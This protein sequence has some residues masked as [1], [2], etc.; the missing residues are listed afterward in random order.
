MRAM[1]MALVLGLGIGPAVSQQGSNLNGGGLSVD[2]SL[3]GPQRWQLETEQRLRRIENE[4]RMQR[5]DQQNQ[6][7]EM[8]RR[9][10]DS[11][12]R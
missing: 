2:G 12:G 10:H 4:Q 5:L 9:T 7:E 11:W 6:Y 3:L 1:V 8:R